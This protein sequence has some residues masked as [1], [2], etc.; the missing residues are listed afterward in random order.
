MVNSN[1]KNREM[2]IY[3]CT[4][5]YIV[6]KLGILLYVNCASKFLKNNEMSFTPNRWVK[7]KIL[8]CTVYW[9][10]WKQEVLMCV[11]SGVDI[12]AVLM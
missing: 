7:I 8:D 3:M 10:G 12:A 6:I 9:Q 5:T 1:I 11:V 4:D 2:C